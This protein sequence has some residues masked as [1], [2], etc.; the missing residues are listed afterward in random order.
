[1]DFDTFFFVRMGKLLLG[2]SLNRFLN[3]LLIRS[4]IEVEVYSICEIFISNFL[5][6][7]RHL[8]QNLENERAAEHFSPRNKKKLFKYVYWS[9]QKVNSASLIHMYDIFMDFGKI[10][11]EK[12]ISDTF[13]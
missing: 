3:F 10:K 2:R 11:T 8:F 4:R 7:S 6:N 13:Y 5:T 1:M 12:F 9:I